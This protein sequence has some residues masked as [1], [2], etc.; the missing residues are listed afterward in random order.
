MTPLEEV[1]AM[2]A[3]FVRCCNVYDVIGVQRN[4]VQ[5]NTEADFRRLVPEGATTRK[6]YDADW[7]HTRW[8]VEANGLKIIYLEDGN[9]ATEP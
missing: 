9:H 4:S 3:E 5:V 6:E 1:K 8:T 7:N 2:H